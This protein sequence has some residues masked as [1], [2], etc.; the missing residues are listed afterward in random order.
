MGRIRQ[1]DGTRLDHPRALVLATLAS[2]VALDGGHGER[3]RSKLLFKYGT[4]GTLA[5]NNL[6][7]NIW[8]LI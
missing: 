6:A 4:H 5:D 2:G 8:L 3:S 1:L 7:V